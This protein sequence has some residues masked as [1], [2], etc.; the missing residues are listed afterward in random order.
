MIIKLLKLSKP[1]AMNKII[2]LFALILITSTDTVKP[3]NNYKMVA[4]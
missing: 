1:K 4:K 2:C 3:I